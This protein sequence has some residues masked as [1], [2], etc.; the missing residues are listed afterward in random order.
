ME[1]CCHKLPTEN[2]L[3]IELGLSMDMDLA[4]AKLNLAELHVKKKKIRRRTYSTTKKIRQGIVGT[5][6]HD[7]RSNENNI[8]KGNEIICT[9]DYT[10]IG[11]NKDAAS[12]VYLQ[13]K[14]VIAS[15]FTN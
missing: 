11:N 3:A 9:F 1:S 8:K 14:L 6:Y 10:F 2:I 5:N 13:Q 12:Q 7:E 4:V 15:F